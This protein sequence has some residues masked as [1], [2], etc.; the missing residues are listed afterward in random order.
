ME[1]TEGNLW[2]NLTEDEDKNDLLSTGET[3][4]LG[5]Q[6]EEKAA[7]LNDEDRANDI[8]RKGKGATGTQHHS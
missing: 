3:F 5:P 1:R 8:T 2:L 4:S 6:P 7:D